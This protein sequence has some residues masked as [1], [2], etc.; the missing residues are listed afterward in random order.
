MT[1]RIGIVGTGKIAG[2]HA[3]AMSMTDQVTLQAVSSR[4]LASAE[5]FA[6]DHGGAPVEGVGA[7]LARDD[8]DAVYI[9]TP[10]SAKHDIA[11]AALKAGRHVLIEKPLANA[12][13][14]RALAEK[15]S[16]SGLVFMDA[17]HFSHNPRTAIIRD[18]LGQDVGTPLTL[19]TNFH[20][21][22]GGSE[23]IRYDPVLE[24]YGALGDLGWYCA[25]LVA[26]LV[27]G[28]SE[29]SGCHAFGTWKDG[30]LVS[31]SA[32]ITFRNDGFRL[33]VDCGFEAGAFC[34]E[35]TLIG[36]EGIISMDDFVHDWERARIGE[37]KP[38][39]PAGYRLRRGRSDPSTVEFIQTPGKKSHMI[40]LLENFA[41]AAAGRPSADVS[42]GR[43]TERTQELLDDIWNSLPEK[44]SNRA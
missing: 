13:S 34:Q 10:T 16:S 5:A 9:A 40:L 29:T 44:T 18:R 11:M 23:N 8:I 26:E 3:H 30:A 2:K 17:T 39:F 41:A 27:P 28:A 4:R 32:V 1:L 12:S 42:G 35:A 38:Q 33:I 21:D 7:L 19:V 36:T 24:P 31:V 14:A 43:V 15:A 22:V 25:R 6:A 37:E 20:A